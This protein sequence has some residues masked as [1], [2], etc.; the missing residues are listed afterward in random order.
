VFDATLGVFDA[1]LGVFDAT[2][3]VF[4]ATLGGF[5]AT[6]GGLALKVE[7]RGALWVFGAAT[8]SFSMLLTPEL[9]R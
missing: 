7:R 9:E 8:S 1:T 3:G 4:D 6:L 2:L 5:D